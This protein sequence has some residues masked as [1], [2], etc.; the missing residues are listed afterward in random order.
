MTGATWGCWNMPVNNLYTI[1]SKIAVNIFSMRCEVLFQL[2]IRAFSQRLKCKRIKLKKIKI[3]PEPAAA[4]IGGHRA[5][6]IDEGGAIY[7][8][9][10]SVD[11]HIYQT[12]AKWFVSF[13]SVQVPDNSGKSPRSY[14]PVKRHNAS[15]E[16]FWTAQAGSCSALSLA[17]EFLLLICLLT[18]SYVQSLEL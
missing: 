13:Y 17:G 16:Q 6:P 9:R 4:I 5:R 10:L 18:F 2:D 11:Y 8:R 14:L 15:R 3:S 1:L 12:T 7:V